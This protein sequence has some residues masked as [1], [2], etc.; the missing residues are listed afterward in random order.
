MIVTN[1][2]LA[3]WKERETS[4]VDDC[5]KLSPHKSL[6]PI[7]LI[8]ALH[9]EYS[10]QLTNRSRIVTNFVFSSTVPRQ[11]SVADHLITDIH[12]LQNPSDF[13][14][15]YGITLSSLALLAK[16]GIVMPVFHADMTRYS[17]LD[18]LAE[19]GL[20]TQSSPSNLRVHAV[21]ETL[22][23]PTY[24]D[25]LEHF[26]KR[27][28]TMD[29]NSPTWRSK[30]AA[31]QEAREKATAIRFARLF[32][33]TPDAVADENLTAREIAILDAWHIDPITKAFGRDAWIDDRILAVEA[34]DLNNVSSLHNLREF[35]VA[36]AVLRLRLGHNIDRVEIPPQAWRDRFRQLVR[37]ITIRSDLDALS[38]SELKRRVDSLVADWEIAY[39]KQGADFDDNSQYLT[40]ALTGAEGVLKKGAPLL[41]WSPKIALNITALGLEL[42]GK[43]FPKLLLDRTFRW[44][45][46]ILRQWTH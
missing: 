35:I 32:A 16:S 31:G 40:L 22:F 27:A 29:L 14:K 18:Y 39:R 34:L 21:F 44:R 46:F 37:D 17:G 8:H 20:L 25:G 15:E 38:P 12:P 5:L 36:D 42:A 41:P 33:L 9:P 28:G 43:I 1:S 19:A 24:H 4:I 26:A 6:S 10:H 30:Y 3:A 11:L 13:T 23:S 2:W 7:E 45:Y